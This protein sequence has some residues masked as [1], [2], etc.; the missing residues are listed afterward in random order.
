MKKDVFCFE[1]AHPLSDS[2]ASKYVK[3]ND[4]H[5]P[6]FIDATLPRRD[7]GDREYYCCTMLTLFKLWRS[8]FDLK[9]ED[10]SLDES[11]NSYHFTE[12]QEGFMNNFNICYECL[13]AQ[14]DHRAQLKKNGEGV[15]FNSWDPTEL[16][17]EELLE[18]VPQ[19]HDDQYDGESELQTGALHLKQMHERES[20]KLML[21]L[22]SWTAP[23]EEAA[24]THAAVKPNKNLN[25]S[26][27]EA[28]VEKAKQDELN[29][30]QEH[31]RSSVKASATLD[32]LY[33]T[34]AAGCNVVKVVDKSYLCHAFRLEPQSELVAD[35]IKMYSLNAEQEQAFRIVANHAMS[36]E[37][38]QLRMYLGSME[39][40]GKSQVI[41]SLAHFFASRNEAHRFIVVA[42]TGMAAAILRGATYYSMFGIHGRMNESRI[43]VVKSRLQGV[44]YMFLDE[45]SM[46]SAQ[47][48]YR[49]HSQLCKVLG[50]ADKLFGGVNIVFSGD[51]TQLPPTIGGEK[52]ALYSGFIGAV[53]FDSKS[54]E[55]EAISKALWH[56]VTTV[57]ILRQNMR[58][59]SQ[60]A[61]D[62]KLR[63]A[64]E[65]MRYKAC[66]AED[67]AFLRTRILSSTPGRS[68]ICDDNFRDVSIIT[69]TNLHKDE[70]NRLG[71]LRFAEESNQALTHFY[72]DDTERAN[73]KD[74]ETGKNAKYLKLLTDEIQRVLWNLPPSS[75]DK[76]I[77][78]TLSLCIGMPVMIRYNYATELCM[79]RGQ[80]GYVVGWQ[81]KKGPRN[82][83]VLD[84]LF[85][86]LKEPP[87]HVKIDGL[88]ANVIPIHPTTNTVCVTLPSGS[89]YFIQR[90]QVEVLVNFAMTDFASQGKTRRFNVADLNNLHSHQAYYTA[91]SRSATAEGTLIVQGF[92]AWKITGGCS[93]FLRQEFR[94]L[95]LLDS[96]TALMHEDR[97]PPRV[98][99][100]TRN[101]LILNFRK[102]KG[103]HYVPK[104][105][106]HAI[107]WSKHDPLLESS[108]V[109]PLVLIPSAARRPP[110][111]SPKS[112]S[113]DRSDR[114]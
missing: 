57:V 20:V 29:K 68:S 70:I 27:W 78:G 34:D 81:A 48:L 8:G 40:T 101:E 43:R 38:D 98:F 82:Q 56:Q 42:P 31:N 106:P 47:D 23:K 13:D 45:V 26:Q 2:H 58:Q 75:T 91:L 12:E 105:V 33:A 113:I 76:H 114:Q 90:K 80:E 49:I 73:Q 30:K 44:D 15:L 87:Y 28:E 104:E 89:Q 108:I 85:V 92:D 14:D 4:L 9:S 37:P 53:S 35:T 107:R 111:V 39:G 63:K 18:S 88:P 6:S 94:E 69:G 25:A 60:T 109:V 3:N 102:W 99:G 112:K 21:S 10:V 64:L 55:A 79:T 95:E 103:L 5:V 86:E 67:V 72:S 50:V 11:F 83:Q 59:R 24:Q 61:D 19:A 7:K 93:G 97:L 100:G 1:A 110:P 84:T 36:S 32:P 17:G 66:T 51:F 41:K 77:P 16:E 52:V 62:A 65:N 96:I 46:L 22:L 54:Q 74:T 71:A